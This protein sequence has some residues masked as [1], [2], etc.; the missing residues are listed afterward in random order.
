MLFHFT[1]AVE[2]ACY[3]LHLI[4]SAI[5]E[6][7]PIITAVYFQNLIDFVDYASNNSYKHHPRGFG[8][9]HHNYRVLRFAFAHFFVQNAE[10]SRNVR[11]KVE[12]I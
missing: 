9:I 3:H 4:I 5:F 2:I 8:T 11:K 1:V 6:P 7:F 10:N 12:Y